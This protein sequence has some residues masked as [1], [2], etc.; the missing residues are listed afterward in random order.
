VL[1]KPPLR[2]IY[3]SSQATLA[4]GCAS[5]VYHGLAGGHDLPGMLYGSRL[6]PFVAAALAYYL[7]N[8]GSVSLAVALSENVRPWAAWKRNF[9]TRYDALTAFAVI[10]LGAL[11]ASHYALTGATG[12]LLVV[13][14]LVLAYEG[15][16][17]YTVRRTRHS[18][19]PEEERDAA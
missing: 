1:R 4:V 3:N 19:T 10:S 9:G 12:T 18:S 7:V 16:R 17:L 15:L 13:L 2:V 5:L 6:F 14:P 11:L 8:T